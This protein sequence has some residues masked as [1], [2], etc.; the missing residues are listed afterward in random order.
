MK[1]LMTTDT[2][3]GA[4]HFSMD[5]AT[6]LI[7]EKIE[8]ILVAMGP[9]LKKGQEAEIKALK[10]AG[11]G[12]YHRDFRLE[13]MDDPWE[14]I[15]QAGNWVQSIY[16][17]ERPD[18]MHFNNYSLVDLGWKVPTLL[19]AHSCVASWWK[20]VKKEPLPNRFDRYMETVQSAFDNANVVVS[21]S[22]AQLDVYRELYGSNSNQ[23]VVYNGI[24]P[25][26]DYNSN[27]LPILFSMGRLW[28]DAKNVELII[29]A[30][31]K[32]AGEI[33]IAGSDPKKCPVPKM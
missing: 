21:P 13:W 8:V 14:D 1:I 19:V 10:K 23:K 5:L 15:K 20:A 7:D 11:V 4:W 32:I 17:K 6:C 2:V 26:P 28:D 3:G 24:T 12:F 16:E 30:A 9:P 25:A 29:K 18:L 22:Q 31:P 33:F 27:K